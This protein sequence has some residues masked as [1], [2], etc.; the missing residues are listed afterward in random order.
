MEQRN[1]PSTGEI[2]SALRN[3]P[4]CDDC[5]RKDQKCYR[6]DHDAADRL[7]SQERTITEKDAEI[8]RLKSDRRG[9]IGAVA[10]T[11]TCIGDL[12]E[13]LTARAEQAE[14]TNDWRYALI[15][16]IN[17]NPEI[18]CASICDGDCIDCATSASGT[19]RGFR[20]KKNLRGLPQDGGMK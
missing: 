4:N 11:N 3:C 14:N 20:I 6:N 12:I 7:E 13:R 10:E 18:K 8:E 15:K 17:E 5:L 2:V 9:I 1:D 16:L 19:A